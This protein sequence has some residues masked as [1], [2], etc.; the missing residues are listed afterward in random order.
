MTVDDVVT[1]LEAVERSGRPV[2]LRITPP[3]YGRMRAR[4]H[5]AGGE[6]GYDGDVDPIHLDPRRL[7]DDDAPR[8]PEVDE[9]EDRLEAEEGY[10]T[11]E[12]RARH[13]EAVERWRAAV[14]SH[15]VGSIVVDAPGGP[16][17]IEVKRL[18]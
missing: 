11:E 15:V 18:G 9:T 13:V 16:H 1:A 12:H 2:V 10:S 8:Y 14:R 4:L 17:E 7:V 6:G 5:V 3:F